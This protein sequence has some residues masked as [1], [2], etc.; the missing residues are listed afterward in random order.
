M[1]IALTQDHVI[2]APHLDLIAIL[3]VEQHLITG[4][5]RSHVGTYG[6]DF[7]PDQPFAHLGGRRDE[8]ATG[9]TTLALGAAH[10]DQYPVVQHLDGKVLA[11]AA[12]ALAQH[13]NGLRCGHVVTVPSPPV[14]DDSDTNALRLLTNDGLSLEAEFR[15]PSTAPS[16]PDNVSGAVVLAHPHPQ[17]GGSMASLVT[18]E[19]FRL[20]PARGLGVLRF[21][22]R[23]VG[24]SEGSYGEG[25][26]ERADIV[27]AIDALVER[28]PALPLVLCGWSFGG[29]TSLSVVDERLSGWVAI[30]PP[31]RILP[32]D[33]LS[34]A[35]GADPR[36]KLLIVPEHDQ[37]RPPAAATEATSDWTN[38]RIEPIAG[39]D[40]FL[41]GRTE[42]VANLVTRFAQ[43]LQP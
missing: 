32:L 21:N 10:I 2:V 18:S 37:F 17:Q 33:E 26:A 43:E 14:T 24:S 11:R 5:H 41:V 22:F 25:R 3:R 16:A 27:A 4:F 42:K 36:P 19:L 15:P 12:D 38:T 30:A 28:W 8:D 9:G 40:H 13:L 20:L 39:A 7:G 31:L 6:D 23:G 35:S 34:A 29:D 1:N